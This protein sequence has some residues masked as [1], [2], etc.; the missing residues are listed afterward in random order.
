[1]GALLREGLEAMMPR[2]EFM[3]QV[4]QRGLMIGIELG[5][6]R[7]LGLRAVW[8]TMNAMSPDLF[9]QG[10]VIPLMRDHR[11]ITQ[12]AGN[13]LSVVK[14]IPPLVI[15]ESDVRWFL[16]AWDSVMQQM[17]RVPGPLW[18]VLSTLARGATRRHRRAPAPIA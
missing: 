11:I 9:A 14:L 17:H 18:D 10:A 15:D 4:R 8:S 7:S 13:A 1:M 16:E 5:P 12:V 3:K 6:P 2:Y